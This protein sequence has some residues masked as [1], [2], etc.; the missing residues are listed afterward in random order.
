MT[1]AN[2][3]DLAVETFRT[4][5]DEIVLSGTVTE[6]YL[7]YLSAGPENRWIVRIC[8]TTPPVSRETIVPSRYSTYGPTCVLNV[9]RPASLR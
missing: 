4:P 6:S 8:I 2:N 5:T 3:T 9:F 1:P 7:G